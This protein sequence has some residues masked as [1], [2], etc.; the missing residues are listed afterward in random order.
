MRGGKAHTYSPDP[1]GF[2]EKVGYYAFQ[3]AGQLL[4]N[5][6][7][8]LK[9]AVTRAI[10]KSWSKKKR[11]AAQGQYSEA[12]PDAVNIS[13][14]VSDALE[15]VFYQNDKSVALVLVSKCWGLQDETRIEA[16]K[17]NQA[18]GY[19]Q[20]YSRSQRNVGE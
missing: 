9:I 12:T 13:A 18:A 4:W 19:A 2:Q 11:E 14:V 6:P 17:I 7:I 16:W 15:G 1:G 8:G 3:E 10:P 20:A 5:G